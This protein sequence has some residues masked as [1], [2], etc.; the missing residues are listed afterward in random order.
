MAALPS[1]SS[2]PQR[3]QPLA[4]NAEQ[5]TAPPVRQAPPAPIP[6]IKA[7]AANVDKFP[8]F[9]HYVATMLQPHKRGHNGKPLTGPMQG[10]LVNKASIMDENG[11]LLKGWKALTPEQRNAHSMAS[12]H[13]DFHSALEGNVEGIK[14]LASNP[15]PP[16]PDWIKNQPNAPNGPGVSGD[17]MDR[18]ATMTKQQFNRRDE[19]KTA[20]LNTHAAQI[21]NPT[22]TVDRNT[23]AKTENLA[24]DGITDLGGGRMSLSNKYGTGAVLQPGDPGYRNNGPHIIENG[25]GVKVSDDKVVPAGAPVP[26][27][28]SRA[29]M[30]EDIAAKTAG[31]APGASDRLA[32]DRTKAIAR[33]TQENAPMVGAA[34]T[35]LGLDEAPATTPKPSPVVAPMPPKPSFMATDVGM[36]NP[37][38]DSMGPVP[39]TAA[40]AMPMMRP[41]VPPPSVVAAPVAPVDPNAAR[42]AELQR[43]IAQ[44]QGLLG[45][46]G[47]V[48][49][50]GTDLAGQGMD[51]A[52][53]G[54]GAVSNYVA[55]D[56]A[57]VAEAQ[58]QLDALNSPVVNPVPPV[59]KPVAQPLAPA[60]TGG[61]IVDTEDPKK[62]KK[63]VTAGLD[64]DT[65]NAPSF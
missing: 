3:Q 53:Q 15:Q 14:D 46:V 42:R 38:Q 44:N 47:N 60:N 59:G 52:A 12:Q 9:D 25:Q 16:V 49:K 18:F 62:K 55:G 39:G 2:A 58:K 17:A 54:L 13:G 32:A 5:R 8:G 11:P 48:V 65:A 64:S 35:Q 45:K 22:A 50:A 23:Q 29:A 30:K 40:P 4:S 56:D 31:L 7:S 51:K 26:G 28:I 43:T 61:A 57:K 27:G 34:K 36:G 24:K 37:G 33:Q 19:A 41:P 63:P 6:S 10:K 1:V 21:L 20:V